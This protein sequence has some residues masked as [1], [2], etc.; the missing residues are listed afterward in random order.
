MHLQ[1][2]VRSLAS[3]VR[4][5][6]FDRGLLPSQ[7][8]PNGQVALTEW[9]S[10][11]PGAT[12]A[13]VIELPAP[14]SESPVEARTL[15]PTHP[16]FERFRG[17]LSARPS[18]VA[19]IPGAQLVSE[20]GIVL[21]PDNRVLADTAWD[22][23]QL[24]ASEILSA[25]IL[26][27][28]RRV[29]GR[30]ASIVSQWCSA[31]FHWVLD[32][33]PRIAVLERAGMGELPL[34]VPQALSPFQRET[35]GLLGI[36]PERLTPHSS[37]LKPDVL[38][39]PAPAGHT[40][41]PPAWAVQWLRE[42]FATGIQPDGRRLYIS[43]VGAS[44]RRVTN[45]AALV[46]ALDSYGFE[47]VQPEELAL[48]DQVRLFAEAAIVVAPHGGA[49]TNVAF[50]ERVALIEIFE[51]GYV[52]ACFCVLAGASGHDYWYVM[53]ESQGESD[54]RVPLDLVIA[55]VERA[56]EQRRA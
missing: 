8:G 22:E 34:I 13:D 39:W 19:V 25:S 26:P 21:L 35:L 17:P 40:G 2:R 5:A 3:G 15:G 38:V 7:P 45:E 51:P 32:A 14:Q 50:A 10:A 16:L 20:F 27:R 49:N 31:Y 9:M 41:N 47:A 11:S 44:R 53:G 4:K 28:P 52:N 46:D 6:A 1:S 42:R 55:T 29:R 24:A 48:G 56:L 18:V 43:R 30:H 37:C 36:G 23:T 54:I 33:L 12:A